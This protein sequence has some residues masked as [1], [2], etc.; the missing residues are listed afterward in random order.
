VY[1]TYLGGSTLDSASAIV[2]DSSGNAYVT[3]G[4]LSTNFPTVN[5]FQASNKATSGTA[6][7]AELSP[8]PAAT[9]SFSVPALSFGSLAVDSASSPQSVTVTNL[10][11]APLSITSITASGDFALVTTAASC[12]YGGGAVA[13]EANCT[14]DVTFTPTAAGAR[15]GTVTVTDNASGSPH[16]VQLSGT[17]F[18]P[19]ASLSASS[20]TFGGQLL[21]TSSSAQQVTLQNTGDQAL[22]ITSIS[23]TGANSGDFSLSQNCGSSL[24]TSAS[25]QVSVTFTPTASGTRTGALTIT[26]NAPNSPQTLILSGTGLAP[27]V[28][29]SATTLTFAAQTVLTAS[30]P[31]TLTLTDTGNGGLTPL[32]ITASGDFAQTN[33]CADSVAASASCTIS[34]TFTPTAGGARTGALTVTDNAPGSPQTV[35]LSGTGLAPAVNLS[36]TTLTF[37]AQ[38]VSTQS[39]PQTITLTNT[40]NGAL[41]PLTITASGDFT[42]TNT[43]AGSV[44]ASASCTISVTFKPTA[45]G[46]RSGALTLTDNASNSSQ[47]IQL[48]G[49]GMDFQ[50]SSSATSQTVTAGLTANYSLTLAPLGGFNQTVS[51]TC[52][53][54]PSLSTCTLTPSQVTLNGSASATVAVAVSTTAGSLAPPQQRILPPSFTGLGRMFWLFAFLALA[55]LAAQARARRRRAACLL[56]GCLLLVVL[57]AAC[58]GGGGQ[59]IHTPGTPTGTY[60]VNVTATDATASALAHTL[61]LTLTVE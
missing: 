27:V 35:T 53:G 3:G 37:A 11:N 31:Q 43:C 1:S 39:A 24:A 34:V 51:L 23:L 8:G 17:A 45:G 10:G 9:V 4:T 58:G 55:S 15:T 29:L 40:G 54:A 21:G 56:G 26:D 22:S 16:T 48:S 60:T 47:T 44:A 38:T 36:A 41:T 5:P 2:V 12:P 18:G 46:A 14:L 7:V 30:A 42:Q 28:N 49:T 59:V 20:L 57:W 25:C 32:T 52:S 33:T 19:G 50:M 6:F 13:P 61:Q